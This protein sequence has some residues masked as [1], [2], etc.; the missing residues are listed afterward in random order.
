VK[1]G[2]YK[3]D[4]NSIRQKIE[5]LL[6]EHGGMTIS[7]LIEEIP[8]HTKGGISK[9]ICDMRDAGTIYVK[10]W[11]MTQPGQKRHPRPVWDHAQN[12]KRQPPLSKMRP[13]PPTNAARLKHRRIRKGFDVTHTRYMYKMVKTAQEGGAE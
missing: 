3:K 9:I 6:L 10:D 2:C 5:D 12:S 8:G 1:R 4:P 7:D 11:E 13:M